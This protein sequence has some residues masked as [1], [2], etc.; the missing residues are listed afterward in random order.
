M[1]KEAII[2]IFRARVEQII[3]VLL[4]TLEITTNTKQTS[5]IILLPTCDIMQGHNMT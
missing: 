2:A 1:N 3:Y 5:T 4:L